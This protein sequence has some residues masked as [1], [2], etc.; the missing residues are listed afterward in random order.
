MKITLARALKI[1][2]IL[3]GKLA[4][5]RAEIE[6]KNSV[7]AGTQ[8]PDIAALLKTYWELSN[9]II[10][11]KTIHY[12]A[13]FDIQRNLYELAEIKSS[14]AFY[15]L[16]NTND[17]D[18]GQL[19]YGSNTKIVYSA[20]IKGEEKEKKIAELESNIEYL[21]EKIDKFNHN[22]EVSVNDS[23]LNAAGIK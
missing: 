2:N 7:I 14:L 4:K 12:T 13:N 5:V 21:Q 23:L 10:D 16:I 17:G 1:K 22:T 20:V 3:V 11:L 9:H 18:S 19:H 8:Q 6:T 15:N